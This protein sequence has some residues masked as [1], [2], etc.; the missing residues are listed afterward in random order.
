MHQIKQIYFLFIILT[1]L[2]LSSCFGNG[3]FPGELDSTSYAETSEN[4]PA[5][6]I[7]YFQ[8]SSTQVA[9]G[10]II[11]L[12]WDTQ[13]IDEIV[14]TPP[15]DSISYIPPKG[16][17]YI[18]ITETVTY[19]MNAFKNKNPVETQ[20]V[21]ITVNPDQ[22]PTVVQAKTQDPPS[23]P[24]IIT[25]DD[26]NCNN[27]DTNK[28]NL[29]EA[30]TFEVS[31]EKFLFKGEAIQVSWS[32]P[33]VPQHSHAILYKNNQYATSGLTGII[34]ENLEE[35]TTY[36][37]VVTQC[38]EEITLEKHIPI[39]QWETMTSLSDVETIYQTPLT[40][41]IWASTKEGQLYRKNDPS[42]N[43]VPLF[44]D[45]S[46]PFIPSISSV[47]SIDTITSLTLA[48]NNDLFFATHNGGLFKSHDFGST[49]I[50]SI[51]L[52]DDTLEYFASIHAFDAIEK[53]YIFYPIHFLI[54]DPE[55]LSKL[56]VGFEHGLARLP[57]CDDGSKLT[58]VS[59]ASGSNTSFVG[60]KAKLALN[61]ENTLYVATNSGLYKRKALNNW[62]KVSGL[63][64]AIQSLKS[65]NGRFYVGTSQGLFQS[66]DGITWTSKPLYNVQDMITFNDM[67]L[68]AL[69]VGLALE[70]SPN[71][72][73]QLNFNHNI[74][75]LHHIINSSTNQIW[76]LSSDGQIFVLNLDF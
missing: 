76:A 65:L 8:S 22:E 74:K 26:Q 59:L 54:P 29:F 34:T 56:Y 17:Q 10:D 31:E 57:D 36:Q 69:D 45:G 30:T 13:G 6:L 42:Q 41:K 47:A 48:C 70:R 3:R 51:H 19:E 20:A 60:Q 46:K 27:V 25:N 71:Q 16:F 37:L 11:M 62:E 63:A 66:L 68:Y 28:A 14:I 50:P 52:E 9:P 43:W 5:P 23:Y 1:T 55:G 7:L 33:G 15:I 75:Q 61:F 73:Y 21:T 39:V 24:G 38:G 67:I 44:S 12:E 64:G 32:F 40:N 53:E 35:D 18:P 72:E 49:T 2:L 4:T 58:Y